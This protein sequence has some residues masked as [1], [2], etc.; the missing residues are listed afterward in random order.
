MNLPRRSILIAL[1]AAFALSGCVAVVD[2]QPPQVSLVHIRILGGGLLNPRFEVALRL[3]NPNDFD[4]PLQSVEFNLD[5]NGARFAVGNSTKAVTVPKK[6]DAVLPVM[7]R[8]NLLGLASQFMTGRQP[9]D[10]KYKLEG[11]ANFRSVFTV[12]INFS[13]EGV[14]PLGKP[15]GKSSGKSTRKSN[16]G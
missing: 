4:L 5:V 9:A 13:R 14:V 1:F 11:V 3:R 12:P 10:I 6:G 2:P 15:V 8:G 16:G 7:V